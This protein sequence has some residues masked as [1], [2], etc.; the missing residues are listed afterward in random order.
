MNNNKKILQES[1]KKCLE[2]TSKDIRKIL[3]KISVGEME[4]DEDVYIAITSML[5]NLES[6][7]Q[8]LIVA[9]ERKQKNESK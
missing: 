4:F 3:A 1:F 8:L 5:G 6:F 7:N 2:M 9:E